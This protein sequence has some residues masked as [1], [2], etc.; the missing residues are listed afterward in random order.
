MGFKPIEGPTRAD[1]EWLLAQQGGMHVAITMMTTGTAKHLREEHG[2][3]PR[4]DDRVGALR[5][6]LQAHREAAR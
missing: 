6:H 1:W 2:V 4:P 3:E 5:T